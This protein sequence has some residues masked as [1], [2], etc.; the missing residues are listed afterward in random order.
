[1]SL[2]LSVCFFTYN[3]SGYLAHAIS[4]FINNCHMNRNDYEIIVSDDG[5]DEVHK[6]KI[7][8]IKEDFGIE[9]VLLNKHRGVGSNFNAGL[10]VAEGKY[11]LHL[12]DDWQLQDQCGNF[13]KQSIAFLDQHPEV[14]IVHLSPL[15][16]IDPLT[17]LSP[18]SDGFQRVTNGENTYTNCP[19][20]KRK[21]LH[22]YIG[23]Y[24]ENLDVDMCQQNFQDIV[25]RLNV[26]VCWAG[27]VFEH[28]GSINCDGYKADGL[29]CGQEV[30]YKSSSNRDDLLD[31]AKSAMNDN[32]VFLARHA[33]ETFLATG[34]ANPQIEQSFEIV[35]EMCKQFECAG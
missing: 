18:Y 22:K 25:Y 19:H 5:S 31:L 27:S 7:I 1:M 23:W 32:K 15:K 29:K 10:R 24:G 21:D 33:L 13:L 26:K 20:L 9:K 8:Q 17:N 11:V 3:R 28:F 14:S 35:S 30:L 16:N 34:S 6:N 4:E 12:E 2:K